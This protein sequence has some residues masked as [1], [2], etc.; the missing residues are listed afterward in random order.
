MELCTMTTSEGDPERSTARTLD[1]AAAGTEPI[2]E[3]PVLD[4]VVGE[5]AELLG[6]EA[7]VPERSAVYAGVEETRPTGSS[8]G[9]KPLDGLAGVE[10]WVEE[11]AA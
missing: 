4:L 8:T 7:R 5:P 3:M 10:S 9:S 6:A 11:V 1:P 2:S